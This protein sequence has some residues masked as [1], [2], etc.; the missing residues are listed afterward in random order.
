[1]TEV[2]I[3]RLYALRAGYLL[4]GAGLEATIW[5]RL[6]SHT[7]AW[8]LMNSVVGAMLGGLSLLALLGLRYPL[9]MLPVLL[10]E[11][12]WKTIWLTLVALPLWTS[13]HLDERTISTVMECLVGAILIP[14]VPWRYVVDRYVRAP[15]APWRRATLASGDAAHA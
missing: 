7:A 15:S 13:N 2:S 3:G 9:Q 5:P 4:I 14:L 6:I 10:F 11:I 1:M 8:P 12:V